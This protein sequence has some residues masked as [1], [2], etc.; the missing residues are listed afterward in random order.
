MQFLRFR[1]DPENQCLWRRRDSAEDERVLLTPKAYA[2]LDYLL[3]HAGRLVT[4]DELLDAVWARSYVQ[5]E[6]LK[7]HVLEIRKALEDDARSPLYIETLPRRGYRFIAP[8]GAGPTPLPGS[9]AR[10]VEQH[11]V[12][13]SAALAA[14]REYLGLACRGQRQLIS[15]TGEPGI[16]KTALVDEFQRQAKNWAPGLRIAL[17]QCVEGFGSQEGYYPLLEALGQ[18][19]RGPGGEAVVDVLASQAPTWLVQLPALLRR[20]HRETLQPELLGATRARMLREIGDALET[21][22]A[23]QPTIR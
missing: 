6:V 1:F 14:L 16:G 2:V 8:L 9:D 17:G 11:L 3:K 21:I 12:G 15:V 22:T 4:Q 19:C 23:S 7:H 18:L 5:P 20:E 13:R 10:P